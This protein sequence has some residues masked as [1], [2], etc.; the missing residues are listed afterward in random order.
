MRVFASVALSSDGYLDDCTPR[1][2]M[3]SGAEDWAE[4]HRLRS[5]GDAILAGAGTLRCDNPALVLREPELREARRLRGEDP[6][7]VKV[8]VSASGRL[9]PDLRFF[10]EGAGR[11]ILFTL[12]ETDTAALEPLAE[13]VRLERI[14]AAAVVTELERRGMERLFVEG[15][16]RTLGAFFA[17]GLVDELRVAVNPAVRVGDPRAPRFD[18]DPA[19]RSVPH[20]VARFGAVE[21]TTYLFRPDTTAED[22]R[23]LRMAI[24]ASRRC[25]PCDSSYC[26]GAAVVAPDG[27]LFTG[28][29]HETSPT[30]HAEQEAIAKAL[31]AGAELR[32]A[33]IYSSMEP[34]STRKSEPHSC[35]ELILRYGF[36]RVIFACYEPDRFVTCRGALALRER[37]VE[38]RV[39]PRLA[40]EVM[41]I[42]GHLFR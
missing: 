38:V 16:A 23:Y 31:A 15:G 14:S 20:E 27:R 24:D 2:L 35:S 26:V 41:E 36:A 29:T 8:T 28:Y 37:G 21:A 1:R 9:A 19:W 11:K 5:L 40:G 32:G 30:R 3:I 13:V 12:P 18:L 10:T 34:C 22:E 42:N 39:L 25:T 6:D 4:V 17:E 33:A 7:P